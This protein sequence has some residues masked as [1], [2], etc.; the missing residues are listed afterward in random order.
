[1][2]SKPQRP[3][4]PRLGL[5]ALFILFS[6]SYISPSTSIPIS[7]PQRR[8]ASTP[9]LFPLRG[10]AKSPAPASATVTPS[11]ILKTFLQTI[12]SARSHLAA[13]ACARATSI[14]AMYPVDTIKTRMQIGG[15]KAF[16]VEGL[17]NG[18]WGSLMG[19][20]PY[21]WV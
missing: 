17:Y 18:V 6:L 2:I 16:R 7:L 14:F 11:S 5:I 15:A 3:Q 9:V 1:M 13:A 20:V 12:S 4:A 21:G 10:G 8:H 19:Q